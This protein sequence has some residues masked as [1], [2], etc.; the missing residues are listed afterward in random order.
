ME[1]TEKEKI[2]RHSESESIYKT[3]YLVENKYLNYINKISLIHLLKVRA[4]YIVLLTK[5]QHRKIK[6]FNKTKN[7]GMS[8]Y[9]QD[10]YITK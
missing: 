8:K 5:N 6:L 2:K 3:L 9:I 4:F 10:K 7:R 1:E